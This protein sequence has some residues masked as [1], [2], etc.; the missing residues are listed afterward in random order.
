MG[1]LDFLWGLVKGLGA[2]LLGGAM[3]MLGSYAITLGQ[4]II[5]TI[6]SLIGFV[7]IAF[8]VYNRQQMSKK[9]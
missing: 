9:Y 7:S 1:F 8:F 2:L 6:M 4:T 3:F 5:G